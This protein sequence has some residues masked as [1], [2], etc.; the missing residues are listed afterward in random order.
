MKL[1]KIKADQLL[2]K[3]VRDL[4][5]HLQ[6]AMQDED[7]LEKLIQSGGHPSRSETGWRDEENKV[8]YRATKP[9]EYRNDDGEYLIWYDIQFMVKKVD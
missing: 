4:V 5:L 3:F 6:N 1:L 7:E 2:R 8:M 9:I